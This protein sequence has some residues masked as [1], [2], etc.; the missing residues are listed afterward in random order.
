MLA[1]GLLDPRMKIEME[2]TARK[3]AGKPHV[4]G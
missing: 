3:R 2:A 4:A 1:A